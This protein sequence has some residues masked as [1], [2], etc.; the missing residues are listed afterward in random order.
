VEEPTMIVF[1]GDHQPPLKNAF[2]EALYGKPLSQRTTEEVL[3]QYA[4]PFFIWTNY[5]SEEADGVILSPNYLGMLTAQTA[6]LPMTGYMNFLAQL[7]QELP[8][9][10]PVGMITADGEYLKEEELSERQQEWLWRYEMLNY[11]GMKDLFDE[12]REFYCFHTVQE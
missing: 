7:Y 10:T 8:V 5:D 11:S 3:Q 6:G 1:F 9:I 2:Y 12:I 4:T